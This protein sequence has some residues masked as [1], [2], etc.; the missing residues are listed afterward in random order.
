MKTGDQVDVHH[1]SLGYE[2]E[3]PDV[4]GRGVLLTNP[5]NGDVV[6]W[7]AEPINYQRQFRVSTQDVTVLP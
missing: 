5:A 3:G 4:I 6:V 1:V 7:M 2:G